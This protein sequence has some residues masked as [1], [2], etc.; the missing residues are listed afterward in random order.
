LT[1]GLLEVS[2]RQVFP[3]VAFINNLTELFYG[4]CGVRNPKYGYRFQLE[5]SFCFEPQSYEFPEPLRCYIQR[6]DE[7]GVHSQGPLYRHWPSANNPPN[8]RKL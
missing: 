4:Q 5:D 2:L 8:G 6:I 1:T 3:G 7:A